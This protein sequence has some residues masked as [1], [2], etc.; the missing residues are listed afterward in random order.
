[1]RNL[2]KL[3]SLTP[4]TNGF[5]QSTRVG[6]G[7]GGGVDTHKNSNH[8]NTRVKKR[9]HKIT[10]QSYSSTT[11]SDLYLVKQQRGHEDIVTVI[12]REHC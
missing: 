4:Y 1:V 2:L 7:G 9:A 11:C 12:N 8:S 3:E 5:N 6:G 10:Q